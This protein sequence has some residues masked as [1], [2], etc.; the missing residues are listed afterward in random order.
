[1]PLTAS[2]HWTGICFK[3]C[4]ACLKCLVIIHLVYYML[5]VPIYSWTWGVL[6]ATK[7]SESNYPPEC[8]ATHCWRMRTGFFS[9]TAL[10]KSRLGFINTKRRWLFL[11]VAGRSFHGVQFMY[12]WTSR[13]Y[14]VSD[15]PDGHLFHT[16]LLKSGWTIGWFL[17]LNGV[18]SASKWRD[19]CPAEV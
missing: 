15:A 9:T 8:T 16:L 5:L 18:V 19:K 2:L 11:D 13:V 12:E 10:D 6:K 3:Y 1:M 7:R 17:L 14:F 4:P